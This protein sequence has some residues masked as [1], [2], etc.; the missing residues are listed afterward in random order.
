M[1]TPGPT[2]WAERLLMNL[3]SYSLVLG[4]VAF[5]VLTTKYRLCPSLLQS[6]TLV[7]RFVYGHSDGANHHR[8]RPRDKSA[9]NE[10]L[11][12]DDNTS[13]DGIS[14][15]Q[16]R[17]RRFDDKH[18]FSSPTNRL[19]LLWCFLGLQLAYLIWGVLQEK[20]MTTEY[21]VP[22]DY[23]A[24]KQSKNLANIKN[25]TSNLSNHTYNY[26]NS[27]TNLNLHNQPTI[28]FHD[29]QFLVF[30][31]RVVAFIL[32]ILALVF[33]R[34]KQSSSTQLYS[35]KYIYYQ[36]NN[37][38]I[39][40]KAQAP[41]YEYVYCSLSNILSSWCQYEAL[42]YVNFP[43]QVLSKS[44][45]IV[46]VMLVSKLILHKGYKFSEYLCA[47]LLSV[48]MF[49]FLLNQPISIRGHHGPPIAS[50]LDQNQTNALIGAAQDK[51]GHQQEFLSGDLNKYVTNNSLLSGLTILAF[52]LASDSF[53]SNW[54]QNL[55][56]KYQVS[57]WQ[58][59][60]ATNFYSILLTLT[61]LYQLGTL[62]PAIE[63]LV[64]SRAL[65]LDC[66]LMSAMSSI[67]QLFVYYTI[68]QF[69]SVVFATIMTL[70]QFLAILLSCSIYGH[71]LTIGSSAGLI[72]VF[73]VITFQVWHKSRQVSHNASGN[74][75]TGTFVS[76][77][78]RI[79]FKTSTS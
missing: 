51:Q 6:S 18:Q 28:R 27:T 75:S 10:R 66:I 78:A 20:I 55:F 11:L 70:R 37:H 38:S 4:P 42:K 62:K 34:P 44:F 74:K 56:T 13:S 9:D 50:Q 26:V 67:G 7:Q 72:L 40:S 17:G 5:V 14:G 48:G 61:S 32:A 23:R 60:A 30:I 64:V 65:L 76:P 52:Y 25:L 21:Q 35:S 8:S 1:D 36:H 46:P 39:Q 53:T 41:L 69:G 54:Q 71:Q 22:L 31:N 68:K 59:M 43:T 77:E 2:T 19:K 12:I 3:F 15:N 47:L 79:Q 73:M 24:S 33:D 63:L 29:S 45:K 58:M 49:I 16:S 57:N